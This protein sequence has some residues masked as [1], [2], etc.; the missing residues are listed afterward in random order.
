ME[1]TSLTSVVTTKRRACSVASSSARAASVPRRKRP[2]KSISKPMSNPP[3][4]A[5]ASPNWSGDRRPSMCDHVP[6]ADALTN[7]NWNERTIV[8][9]AR[10]SR[11]RAAAIRRS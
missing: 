6:E 10:A 4:P 3:V 5:S 2:Q 11:M 8:T 9:W 7:G 1:A